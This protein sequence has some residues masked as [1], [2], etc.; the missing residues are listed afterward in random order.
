[1]KKRTI[2]ISDLLLSNLKKSKVLYTVIVILAIEFLLLMFSGVIYYA[3]NMN[4]TI[5]NIICVL[6]ISYAAAILVLLPIKL[7]ITIF[8]IIKNK[9]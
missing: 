4:V 8:K 7:L 9:V 5:I 2:Y 6:N 3:L 1:M